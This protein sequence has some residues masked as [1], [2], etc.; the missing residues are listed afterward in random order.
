MSGEPPSFVSILIKVMYSSS[1]GELLFKLNSIMSMLPSCDR[2]TKADSASVNTL[3]A[4]A[5][6]PVMNG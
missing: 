2:L 6:L 5:S 4:V 1:L 3:L